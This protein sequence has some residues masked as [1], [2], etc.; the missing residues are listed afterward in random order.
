MIGKR[1]QNLRKELDLLQKDLAEKLNLSQQTISLYEAGKREPDYE[2][3]NKIAEFFNVSVDF[4]MGNSDIRNPYKQ[5]LDEV[6]EFLLELKRKADKRGIKFD[7]D[8]AE[9]LLDFYE[10]MKKREEK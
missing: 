1:I 9:D 2:T 5:E 8:S 4:L 3:L 10:F 6:D 7:P